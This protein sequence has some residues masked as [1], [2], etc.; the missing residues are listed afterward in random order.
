MAINADP[1]TRKFVGL[2]KRTDCFGAM[3]VGYPKYG[4]QRIP[5]RNKPHIKRV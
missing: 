5:A 3:M 4:Y 1:E 2:S